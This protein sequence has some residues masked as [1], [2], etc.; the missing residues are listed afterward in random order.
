MIPET[1]SLAVEGTQ[2]STL[3]SYKYVE[4]KTVTWDSIIVG[5]RQSTKPGEGMVKSVVAICGF[6]AMDFSTDFLRALCAKLKLTGYRSK[7][8]FDLL[9]IL[10]V[11]KIHLDTYNE[12]DVSPNGTSSKVQPKT[13]NCIFR[14]INILF[15]DKMA[16]KFIRLG[17]R[18]DRSI[19]DSRIAGNDEY[20]WQEVAEE[21]QLEN[22]SYDTLSF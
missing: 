9:R 18:K 13:K 10:A 20:F 5:D 11:G 2:Q 14:L 7:A 17:E 21:Y 22:N 4:V 1:Q 12:N 8:K 6:E 15:S 16:P 19:L 3:T